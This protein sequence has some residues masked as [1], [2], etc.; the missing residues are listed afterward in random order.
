[1]VGTTPYWPIAQRTWGLD[2]TSISGQNGATCSN[3]PAV[4]FFESGFYVVYDDNGSLKYFTGDGTTWSAT[5]SIDQES[6]GRPALAVYQDHLWVASRN[7]TGKIEIS[8]FDGSAWSDVE[9]IATAGE[10]CGMAVYNNELY[11]VYPDGQSKIAY[12]HWNGSTWSARK[13][14]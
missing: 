7:A 12:V 14:M 5:A 8:S 4:T 6:N 1:M 11:V 3:G 9:V 10:N 13:W 2:G